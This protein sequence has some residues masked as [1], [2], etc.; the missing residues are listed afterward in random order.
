MHTSAREKDT[1]TRNAWQS[2]EMEALRSRSKCGV[3]SCPVQFSFATENLAAD[4]DTHYHI[5]S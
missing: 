1:G 5:P 3:S 4:T 2:F